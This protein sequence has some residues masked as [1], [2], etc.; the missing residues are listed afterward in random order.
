MNNWVRFVEKSKLRSVLSLKH[1]TQFLTTW[2]KYSVPEKFASGL[3]ISGWRT[4]GCISCRAPIIGTDEFLV[5]LLGMAFP[6]TPMG[7]RAPEAN[8]GTDDK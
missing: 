5:I 1:Q 2:G 8:F 7:S 3:P 4:L 6:W